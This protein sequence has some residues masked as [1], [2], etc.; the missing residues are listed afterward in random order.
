MFSLLTKLDCRI[1]EWVKNSFIR[2]L[3]I[4]LCVI[5]LLGTS[6]NSYFIHLCCDC[7]IGFRDNWPFISAGLLL[8]GLFWLVLVNFA[9]LSAFFAY[10]VFPLIVYTQYA[11]YYAQ[12]RYGAVREEFA[13][14]AFNASWGEINNYINVNSGIRLFLITVVL[15]VSIYL[16]RRYFSIKG[17]FKYKSACALVLA[18]VG[19]LAFTLPSIVYHYIRP[20]GNVS[21]TPILNAFPRMLTCPIVRT[22]EEA[23]HVILDPGTEGDWD[24]FYGMYQP[25]R[26]TECFYRAIWRFLH[27]PFLHNSADELSQVVWEKLPDVVVFYVGESFRADHNPMNGYHRN[28]L[29]QIS[30]MTNVINFPNLHSTETQTIS[31]IY[32]LLILK[33]EQKKPTHT[34]FIDILCKHGFSS[35]L[36]VGMNSGGAWYDTP[37]IAPLFVDRMALY[38]RPESPEDYAKGISELRSRYQTPLFIMIEDGA[39]HMPY[40]SRT[41]PFGTASEIDKFDNALVDIDTTVSTVIKSIEHEDAILFFASDHGESFGENGRVGHGGPHSAIEQLHIA[42][43]IWYSD[44]YAKNHPEIIQALKENAERFRSLD[45]VYHTIL[46]ICGISSDIQKESDDMTKRVSPAL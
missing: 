42:G 27:P 34:S 30:Q 5:V 2:Y 46:S 44:A 9:R 26:D 22:R 16:L 40:D 23:L 14:A 29:P 1:T 36:M 7:H 39:G 37:L 38:S 6:S 13:V 11:V 41:H 15:F 10:L 20:L 3:I 35:H 12:S 32:S 45:Q 21:A 8:H 25:I 19:A 18:F 24:Y 31:S 33:D 43:F 28:T 4:G 17:N